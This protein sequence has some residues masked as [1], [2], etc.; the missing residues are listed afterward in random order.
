MGIESKI[1]SKHNIVIKTVNSYY[2]LNLCS[3]SSYEITAE[4]AEVLQKGDINELEQNL[5]ILFMQEG[6]IVENSLECKK[7]SAMITENSDSQEPQL[8]AFIIPTYQCNLQCIYCFQQ[9]RRWKGVMKTSML[10]RALDI[11]QEYGA[12]NSPVTLFGGEPLLLKNADLVEFFCREIKRRDMLFRVI[13][14]GV[15]LGQFKFLLKRYSSELD[16]VQVS[17]DGPEEIHNKR[18]Q[19]GTYEKIMEGI[20]NC[21]EAIPIIIRINTDFEN[22]DY[23]EMLIEEVNQR[24]DNVD[25]YSAPVRVSICGKATNN[26][27]DKTKRHFISKLLNL[28]E[29]YQRY[30]LFGYRGLDIGENIAKKG[31]LPPPNIK[32]C[33]P[34]MVF[35]SRGLIF[36]CVDAAGQD[37]LSI[38]EFWPE[39]KF[40]T[41]WWTN[42]KNCNRSS[43]HHCNLL[44]LCGGGCN[45]EHETGYIEVCKEDIMKNIAVSIEYFLE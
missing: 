10:T 22:I 37:N 6:I 28:K 41:N 15:T 26:I 5:K 16:Y 32:F 19:K 44:L 1:W 20:Q 27:T 38:G 31:E 4:T 17:I 7:V 23:I 8:S 39:L 36:P 29:R 24:F 3:G 21:H 43:C 12:T 18:R 9:D 40:R 30:T 45:L 34:K 11:I 25:I 14:N 2:L 35:D 13:T 42:H 33:N